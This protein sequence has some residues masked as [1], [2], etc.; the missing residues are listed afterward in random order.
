MLL[1]S[2]LLKDWLKFDFID[3]NQQHP[4]VFYPQMYFVH[5]MKSVKCGRHA[6]CAC[7]RALGT[8]V[9]DVCVA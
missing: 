8:C 9:R 5:M 4:D 3:P 7:G 6:M 1:H 2:S